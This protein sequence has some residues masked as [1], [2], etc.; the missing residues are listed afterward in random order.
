MANLLSSI[1]LVERVI[2]KCEYG[3][4]NKEGNVK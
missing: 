3:N 4:N 2:V 1:K